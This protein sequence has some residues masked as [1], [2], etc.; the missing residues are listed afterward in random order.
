MKIQNSGISSFIP[1][2]TKL[3]CLILTMFHCTYFLTPIIFMIFREFVL[4]AFRAIE[5][6]LTL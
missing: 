5:C 1:Q 3:F 2:L 6:V 4:A